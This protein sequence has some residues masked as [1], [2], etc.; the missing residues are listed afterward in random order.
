[1]DWN[2]LKNIY[3]KEEKATSQEIWNG[4]ELSSSSAEI[5]LLSTPELVKQYISKY[6]LYSSAEIKLLSTPELVKQYISKWGF[7]D[8][9]KSIILTNN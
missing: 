1:M 2:E 5:K 7:D 9:I 6:R 4:E 8:N 3:L